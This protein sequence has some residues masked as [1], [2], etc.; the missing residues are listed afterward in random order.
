MRK[1][2]LP[3]PLVAHSSTDLYIAKWSIL[4]ELFELHPVCRHETYPDTI[5]HITFYLPGR[6]CADLQI[7][8]TSVAGF[9]SRITMVRTISLDVR[10][11][12]ERVT[13]GHN[14]SP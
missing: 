8:H 5:F 14:P 4:I 12:V 9:S 11:V 6:V 10:F 7:G 3:V 1:Y 13:L 2:F